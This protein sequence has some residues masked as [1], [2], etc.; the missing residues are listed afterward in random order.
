MDVTARHT[1]RRHLALSKGDYGSLNKLLVHIRSF[2]HCF[3]N[4]VVFTVLIMRNSKFL[5]RF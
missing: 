1:R 4:H 2:C 5:S 3:Y